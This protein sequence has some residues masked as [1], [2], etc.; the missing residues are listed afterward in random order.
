MK[1]IPDFSALETV[2]DLNLINW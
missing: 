2:Y 1:N